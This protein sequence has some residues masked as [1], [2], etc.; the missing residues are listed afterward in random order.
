[1]DDND[2]T[3][4]LK[5][6]GLCFAQWAVILRE[7]LKAT[8][9]ILITSGIISDSQWGLITN[10]LTN[11]GAAAIVIGPIIFQLYKNSITQRIKEVAELPN[12]KGVVTDAKT[13]NVDLK[14]SPKVVANSMEIK[15]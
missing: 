13:A 6:W 10:A 3:S 9:I 2:S 5:F 8:G 15:P 14:E 11:L 7:V 1:M 4:S 12:V